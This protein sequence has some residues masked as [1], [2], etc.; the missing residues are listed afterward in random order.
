MLVGGLALGVCKGPRDYSDCNRCS[1]NKDELKGTSSQC[2]R[3]YQAT[4][5]IFLYMDVTK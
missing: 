2:T 5:L 4:R 3:D 1:V